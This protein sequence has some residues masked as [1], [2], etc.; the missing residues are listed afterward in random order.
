MSEDT[1]SKRL[2]PGDRVGKY[3]VIEHVATGGM[4][5]VYRAR[6]LELKRTVALK[7][8]SAATA[9]RPKMIDRFRREARAAA[10]LDHEN[11]VTIYEFGEADGVFFLA[12]EFVPGI[13]L[14][15]YIEKRKKLP[16][17]EALQIVL[18]GAR[19]LAHAHEQNIVHRDVKP[20]NF[21]LTRKD[22][23][24]VVK[25][26][27]MGLA[28]QPGE[29]EFRLTREGTTVGTVDY[30]S[31]E[32]ARKSDSADIRSDIYSLGCTFYHMLAGIAPFAKGSLAER[33]LQHQEDDAPDI[34]QVNKEVPSGYAGILHRMLAKRPEDRYQSPHELLIDLENPDHVSAPTVKPVA[35][36][37]A[38]ASLPTGDVP[39]AR[40]APVRPRGD[41]I[42][43]SA[44]IA[45]A[46][47]AI[48]PEAIAPDVDVPDAEPK[49]QRKPRE[50]PRR[51]DESRDPP[52]FR[53]DLI[54][55][56][57]S[58]ARENAARQTATRDS[59]EATTRKRSPRQGSPSWALPAIGVG[60]IF[61]VVVV[62]VMIAA[63]GTSDSK[64]APPPL[65]PAVNPPVVVSPGEG[66]KKTDGKIAPPNGE[67]GP[68]RP[69]LAALYTPI[70]PFD[71]V[72]LRVEFL[73]G[74]KEMVPP[75]DARVLRVSRG[76]AP[77][78]N[79]FRS[80]AD[81]LAGAPRGSSIIEIH[82]QGPHFVGNLPPLEDRDVFLR[83]G[84]GYRPLIAWEP[85]RTSTKEKDG[86][87]FLNHR[88]GA[89]VIDGLDVVVN[90]HESQAEAPAY[91]FQT[92]GDLHLSNCTFSVAGEHSQGVVLAGIR[93]KDR[94]GAKD[95]PIVTSA[96]RV[97]LSRCYAR[98]TDLVGLAVQSTSADILIDESLLAGNRKPL[99]KAE[100][101]DT[102]EVKLR[103]VG[104][105]LAA[106]QNL[107]H[108]RAAESKGG[109]PRLQVSVWDTILAC[110]ES[111]DAE[112][113]LVRLPANTSPEYLKWKAVN[114]LYAGWRKLLAGGPWAIERSD[115]GLAK[116]QTRFGYPEGD[117]VLVDTW[118]ASPPTQFGDVPAAV[119]Y[120]YDTPAAFAATSGAEPL[121]ARIGSLPPEPPD[122]LARTDP[123]PTAAPVIGPDGAPSVDMA[124]DGLEH[125]G[126]IALMPTDDLGRMLEAR[127]QGKTP[128]APRVVFHIAGS[129]EHRMTPLRVRNVADL[130]LYFEPPAKGA[131]L[132]L[133]VD[134]KGALG[135]AALIDVEHGN[136]ELIGARIRCENS[137]SGPRLPHVVKVSSGNLRVHRCQLQGPMTNAPEPFQAL[138]G[139]GGP[140]ECRITTSVLLSGKGIV[141]AS[142]GG[143]QLLA[144]QTAAV[145]LGDAIQLDL[146]GISEPAP[147]VCQ[148]DSTTWALRQG[149]LSAKAPIELS[150]R[151]GLVQVHATGSS[152]VDPFG[153]TPALSTMLRLPEPLLARGQ[154]AWRGQGNAFDA[155]LGSFC[156]MAGQPSPG[157]QTLADWAQLWGRAG[158]S[159]ARTIGP[160]PA[161]KTPFD[162][163][164]PQLDRLS[165]PDAVKV[166]LKKKG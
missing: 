126:R 98:G 71:P 123:R 9:K 48:A 95:G 154:I 22:G 21:L 112:A 64:K 43:A 91:L 121:G 2:S 57:E 53:E 119:F 67:V 46:P 86:P 142:G 107:L 89:L 5:M 136:L 26:T 165:L 93:G 29:G 76:A 150:D 58:A 62:V 63:S 19:A 97:R 88:G 73:G 50:V 99:V 52:V 153:D 138:I 125:G 34:R 146:S 156:A 77:G 140:A 159:D 105:T 92:T 55:A 109:S 108:V 13:D 152:F 17:E 161:A 141:Q 47:A 49:P 8:L 102:D 137:K 132:V 90:W 101:R 32:Q 16:P 56:R 143:V 37:I 114:S 75:G 100:C 151:L 115:E 45:M 20:S 130:V 81:A 11:I 33:L 164:A 122:W 82:D 139:L 18:Q 118:P 163:D 129:G 87:V 135:R 85:P 134:P 145:A 147:I 74:F 160:G 24:L 44:P 131:P 25:L 116:W 155:R 133:T 36:G 15:D 78:P 162:P 61:L 14:Q 84:A 3:E 103:V 59:D 51:R 128:L 7:V 110:H 127:L 148:L 42:V 28:I 94:P 120:T 158:D 166:L 66:G 113:D 4:G 96:A 104:S 144:K 1:V 69:V 72:S 30:M 80:L 106:A 31:P 35:A 157:K 6:D 54:A 23:K 79:A 68:D 149:L 124:V 12:M 83:A 40:A 65:P 10:R 60:G 111:R 41:E 38:R 39:V 27:D 117:R 70:V